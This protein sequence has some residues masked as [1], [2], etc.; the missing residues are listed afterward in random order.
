ME[1]AI[2]KGKREDD[3][4]IF[5]KIIAVADVYHAMTSERIYRKKQ[6][7]FKVMEMIMHDDFGKFDIA[8]V[9]AL[10]ARSNKLFN[11]K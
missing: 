7:P 9:K 3:I 10:L 1:A 8:I 4:H 6:S 5:S 11:W 2:L